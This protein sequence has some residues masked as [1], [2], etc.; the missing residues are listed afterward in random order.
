MAATWEAL[1]TLDG[2][3]IINK[4][5]A[6]KFHQILSGIDVAPLLHQLDDH[7]ELW[8]S[9]DT[10][11]A[12]KPLLYAVDNI[13]LRYN[14]TQ[15]DPYHW[16]RPPFSVLTAAQ[17]IVFDVMRA[18]PGVHLGKVMISRLRPGEKID[19][20]IDR[21][22]PMIPLY[23]QR[24]QVPLQMAPGVRFMVEDEEVPMVPGTAWWFDN[25][26]MHAVFNDSESD[27]L[28]LFTDIRPFQLHRPCQI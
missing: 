13:V 28:S 3:T 18:I 6:I 25:Q 10:W 14:R 1:L 7:P 26:R 27:R 21:M 17:P 16:D 12:G 15:G 9:D 23:Y 2:K 20:H 24:Y 19:W 8:N 4:G 22:P 11:I 5:M